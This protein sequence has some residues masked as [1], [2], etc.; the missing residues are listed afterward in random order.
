MCSGTA[1]EMNRVLAESA[2]RMRSPSCRDVL[3]S[4]GSCSFFFTSAD[5]APAV[6]RP[7]SQAS[8][9]MMRRKS[10]TSSL[11]STSGMQISHCRRTSFKSGNPSTFTLTRRSQR[12]LLSRRNDRS[13]TRSR[14]PWQP[15]YQRFKLP[16][17]GRAAFSCECCGRQ[18][19]EV[20]KIF[21]SLLTKSCSFRR[22]NGTI[23]RNCFR[24]QPWQKLSVRQDSLQIA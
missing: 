13:S 10:A 24:K 18:S 2:R 17:S 14:S 9:A 22:G 7:S 19:N 23:L 6:E 16:N 12:R 20:Q 1:A 5:C 8:A 21:N 11:L 4:G 15:R 3:P